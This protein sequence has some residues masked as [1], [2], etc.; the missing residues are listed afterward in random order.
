MKINVENWKNDGL[1]TQNLNLFVLEKNEEK[2]ATKGV[3]VS[4][5]F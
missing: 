1:T 5:V 2:K 4:D 3:F